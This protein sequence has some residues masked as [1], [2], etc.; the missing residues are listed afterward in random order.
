MPSGDGLLIRL[1]PPGARLTATAA[2]Q[3]AT[4][5][6]RFGD[7]GVAL[8]RRAAI[9]ARGL[10]AHD[11]PAFAASMVDAGLAESDP[12][13]ERRR[14]VIVAPLNGTDPSASPDA[15]LVAAAI[16]ALLARDPRLARL[17]AKFCVS[18]DGGGVLPL[19]DVGADIRVACGVGACSVAVGG[20][21]AIGDTANTVEWVARLALAFLDRSARYSP[22]PRR[23]RDL[24]EALG[25][26][27]SVI[28]GLDP[29][30]QPKFHAIE[31]P[32]W[33]R[34]S[35]P[36]MT[37]DSS[38]VGWLPYA[39]ANHGAFGLGLPLGATD[40]GCL[41][42]MADL[43]HRFGDGALCLTP[44]RALVIPGV[45]A[46]DA[47]ALREA[48]AALGAIIDGTDPRLKVSACVGRP[49]CARA[50]V[51]AR[52]DAAALAAPGLRARVHVS[53]CAKGCARPG[54][55][56]VT[57]VGEEGRYALLRD[58]GVPLRRGLTLA[59][60]AALIEGAAP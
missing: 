10:R 19:G 34:G 49:G 20:V 25:T 41:A 30:I 43:A 47:A 16:E 45:P 24:V 17:P 52:A 56:D 35:S 9:Q 1:K 38:A 44:W 55:A 4:A 57:L 12:E 18:V 11:V 21:A 7:G 8:T 53:G 58:G 2:R 37:T 51:D 22:P 3:L 14:A 26:F 6:A 46:H 33:T 27:P 32:H 40:A 31:T 48:G 28:A 60:A 59:Q 50:S 29:A 42:H 36:R 13:V 5:A 23:M 39:D 15:P 54:A